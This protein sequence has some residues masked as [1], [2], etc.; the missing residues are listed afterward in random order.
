MIVAELAGSSSCRPNTP[1][2]R[3]NHVTDIWT[4]TGASTDIHIDTGTLAC[5]K[6]RRAEATVHAEVSRVER[7]F[8]IDDDTSIL[9]RWIDDASMKT[10]GEFEE[11]LATALMWQRVSRG[12]FN[13]ST[14]RLRNLWEQAAADG[15]Q[16]SPGE[17]H[18]LAIDITE[19]PYRFDGHVLRQLRNCREVDL[20]A[21]AEG[22]AIDVATE[23]VL[24]RCD[25]TDLTV[26]AFDKIVHRGDVDLSVSIDAF[27]DCDGVSP[28]VTL[29]NAA[30]ALRL[31][32][33]RGPL[34]DG[35]RVAT[36][37][38]DPRTA[39]K[40]K[41]GVSVAVVAPDATTAD[42]VATIV[43][44]MSPEHGISFVDSLNSVGRSRHPS[45]RSTDANSGIQCWTLDVHGALRSTGPG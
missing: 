44:I 43:S 5:S 32:K 1:I 21:I 16:P 25:L 42:A 35:E 14:R 40:V 34:I 3:N 37:V 10:S 15:C 36:D 17:L 30:V 13:V 33:G 24:R 11:L 27:A 12:V 29:R 6:A 4:L 39:R 8:S 18:E 45:E 41:G 26:S 28:T 22:F 23:A 38:F 7:V 19:P 9:N 31:S 2:L 20:S